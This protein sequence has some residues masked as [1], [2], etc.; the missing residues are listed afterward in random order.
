MLK[1]L[2]KRSNIRTRLSESRRFSNVCKQNLRQGHIL[3]FNIH[4]NYITTIIILPKL[5][6]IKQI[7]IY[8]YK[9]IKDSATITTRFDQKIFLKFT[10]N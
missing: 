9:K 1:S 7:F 5:L 2:K 10:K 6:Q 4:Y 8:Y 3:D